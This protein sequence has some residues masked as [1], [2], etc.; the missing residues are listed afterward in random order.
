MQFGRLIGAG[1]AA[2]GVLLI[3][4]QLSFFLSSRRPRNLPG[5]ERHEQHVSAVPGI[6]G[7]VLLIA[8]VVTFFVARL[9]DE[10]DPKHA[11]K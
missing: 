6:L 5:I 9:E 7:G 10:P 2:L 11:I 1:L 8:G 4:L 3:L